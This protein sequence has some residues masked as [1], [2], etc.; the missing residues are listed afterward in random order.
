MGWRLFRLFWEKYAILI[1]ITVKW[2]SYSK[3]KG[4]Q[5][6]FE[7]SWGWLSSLKLK[8][9]FSLWWLYDTAYY[10]WSWLC[11]ESSDST[12]S[13]GVVLVLERWQSSQGTSYRL[14]MLHYSSRNTWSGRQ[15]R[16]ACRDPSRST[17]NR[18]RRELTSIRLLMIRKIWRLMLTWRQP[19]YL[20]IDLGHFEHIWG[21]QTETPYWCLPTIWSSICRHRPF[22]IR[23]EK[24]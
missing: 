12:V 2:C 1:K 7:R 18:S 16:T 19:R 10:Y 24:A 5:T 3:G 14:E 17:F 20:L 13:I 4:L 9:F 23:F 8:A 15:I 11:V 22:E 6:K 21:C